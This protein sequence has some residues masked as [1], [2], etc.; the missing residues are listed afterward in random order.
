MKATN[1]KEI[2]TSIAYNEVSLMRQTHQAAKINI[3]I[4][5]IERIERIN[6]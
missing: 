1:I 3:E 5:K 6:L 4:N 2:F